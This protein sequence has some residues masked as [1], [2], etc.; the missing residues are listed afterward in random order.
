MQKVLVLKSELDYIQTY[1]QFFLKIKEHLNLREIIEL[2][3]LPESYIQNFTKDESKKKFYDVKTLKEASSDD[4]SFFINTKYKDDLTN[5]K[6]GICIIKEEYKHLL[7]VSTM[8]I[9]VKNP[10]YIYTKILNA[11]FKVPQ[12]VITPSISKK[13]SISKTAVI[14]ENVEI[15]DGVFIGDN[16]K[17]GD[18]CKI[19]ANAVLNN[20]IIDKYT[21][22]GANSCISYAEIG[23]N[24]IIQNNSSVGQCGFGFSYNDGFNYKIPQMG[25][26]RVGNYVEIGASSCIDRGAIT[27]TV[28]GDG[29]KIDNL[30]HIAHGVKIGRCCFFAGGTVVAGSTEF[31]NFVQVGGHSAI[32]GHIKIGDGVVIAG[33][34][35]VVKS[36]SPMEKVGGYPAMK[37]MEWE[38][39]MV[40]LS[41]LVNKGK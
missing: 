3:E 37:L 34:S 6:A 31:G 23:Q 4:I 11:F 35:G 36:I 24:C 9:V 2:A 41:N 29:T 10:Y 21:F 33:H 25:I 12:F 8:A 20:C 19:C 30:V 27:D 28:I 16:V 40:R 26:V 15:Q 14:G 32:N 22:V 13:A 1:N 7:P 18:N 17:I 5:T 39:M 38:R